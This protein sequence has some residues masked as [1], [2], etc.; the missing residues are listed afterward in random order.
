MI[1]SSIS[2]NVQMIIMKK[3]GVKMRRE[4]TFKKVIM[5]FLEGVV[6]WIAII[7]LIFAVYKIYDTYKTYNE[8]DEAYGEV[9]NYALHVPEM[10]MDGY[11]KYYVDFD[12]LLLRNQDVIAWIRFD[13]PET[14]NYPIVQSSDNDYYLK[15]D[16]GGSYS[17]AGTVFMDYK[18][19]PDFKDQ[20]TLIYGHNMKNL[21]MFGNLKNYKEQSYYEE[22]PY[23][24]VYTPDGMVGK[25]QIFSVKEV[26]ADTWT[27]QAQFETFEEFKIYTEEMTKGSFYDTGVEVPLSAK[28]LSLYTCTVSDTKRLIVQAL[29][30]EERAVEK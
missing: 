25:Y 27:H 14:I 15:R 26:S 13:E 12:E 1:L 30:V 28:I 21:S 7:V 16:L 19:S 20:N 2:C 9:R 23:F 11:W 22:N 3:L 17:I 10:D 8:I 5:E 29:R 6:L 18:N 4:K 24:Y